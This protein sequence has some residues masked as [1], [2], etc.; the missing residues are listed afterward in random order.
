VHSAAAATGT[1]VVHSSAEV[2]VVEVG[3]GHCAIVELPVATAIILDSAVV[4]VSSRLKS[5]DSV[6]PGVGVFIACEEA[7]SIEVMRV[8]V[9]SVLKQ[10]LLVR[11]TL[12]V[13]LPERSVWVRWQFVSPPH[14]AT[15]VLNHSDVVTT[16]SLEHEPEKVRVDGSAVVLSTPGETNIG[17]TDDVVG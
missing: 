8:A 16:R 1:S 2:N 12:G 17:D 14:L 15:T 13:L 10:E 6:V 7:V 4:A 3:Q 5:E 9:V 11:V